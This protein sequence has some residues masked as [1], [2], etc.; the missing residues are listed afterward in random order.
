MTFQSF[1][2]ALQS[3]LQAYYRSIIS[4]DYHALW[5]VYLRF[6]G[7]PEFQPI[8]EGVLAF[9]A[10]F[11]TFVF[12][13]FRRMAIRDHA[14]LND[15]ITLIGTE[16]ELG[17]MLTHDDLFR[18]TVEMAKNFFSADTVVLYLK[19]SAGWMKSRACEGSCGTFKDYDPASTETFLNQIIN[20]KMPKIFILSKKFFKEKEEV[21]PALDSPRTAMAAPLV[22][23][24][25]TLGLLFTAGRHHYDTDSLKLFIVL[26][27][28]TAIAVRNIQL[29]EKSSTLAKTDPVSG[30]YAHHYI[31]EVLERE[32]HRCKTANLPISLLVLDI[33]DF[34]TV[35]E[36]FGYEGGDSLFK[37]MGA[38]LKTVTRNTDFA[39]RYGGD[40]FLVLL[41]ET[42]RIGGVLVAERIRQ[43]VA[44]YEFVIGSKIVH[45]TLTGA[46]SSYPDG[47]DT[48]KELVALAEE[49]LAKTRKETK[50]KIGLSS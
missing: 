14:R 46:V 12:L 22:F 9:L 26:A 11:L 50:N 13:R 18:V 6:M 44:D 27:N 35:N 29:E 25:Q 28:Q 47:A 5:R 38:V 16:Q 3:V 20:R 42:N 7:R 4:C 39:F 1:Y 41:P 2:Q 43:T 49:A 15:L 36:N 32:F 23:E 31:D 17:S 8:R 37:Q 48:W 40:E 19:D 30:L 24:G 34:K 21:L 10:G 33:D 45:T